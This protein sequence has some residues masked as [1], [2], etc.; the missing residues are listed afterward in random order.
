P[1]VGGAIVLASGFAMIFLAAAAVGALALLL[2]FTLPRVEA[3]ETA[4][5]D[6]EAGGALSGLK[7]A[8]RQPALRPWYLV[9][10]ANMFFVGILFGFLPVRVFALGY[11]PLISGIL[12]TAVAL[13]YLSIQPIAGVLADRVGPAITIRAGLLL[14]AAA[15][16]LIP[17]LSG[18]YLFAAMVLAGIGVGT[19]WTNTD[20]VIS[21]VAPIGRLGATMGVAGSFKEIGDML[22]PLLIGLVSQTFGLTV[23]FVSC[24]ALGL[25]SLAV[26]SLRGAGGRS[27]ADL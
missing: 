23:G 20:A 24:G 15:V 12:L 27:P 5:C 14:A 3:G 4:A 11:G 9:T 19:V 10:L 21:A 7:D 8:L 16:L 26:V 25:L 6:N 2:S 1:L 17:F 18:G 13:A 22:G